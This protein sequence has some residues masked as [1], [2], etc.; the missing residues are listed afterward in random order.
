MLTAL[1]I[2]VLLIT[3]CFR[4]GSAPAYA[5]IEAQTDCGKLHREFDIAM[6]NVEGR[7]PGDPYRR[8][9]LSYAE[10]A[11][12]RMREIGCIN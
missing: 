2:T 4:P 7:E 12:A 8:V 5:R 10:A 6:E 9:S 3:G 11:D 1:F